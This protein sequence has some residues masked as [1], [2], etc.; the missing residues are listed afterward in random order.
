MKL[1]NKAKSTSVAGTEYR[2]SIAAKEWTPGV[3]PVES[4][5]ACVIRRRVTYKEDFQNVNG[6]EAR[7]RAVLCALEIADRGTTVY[8]E[9]DSF[10]AQ[11]LRGKRPVKEPKLAALRTE[12]CDLIL[13]RKLEV[14]YI[15][16]D[17]QD[18]PAQQL[19]D[20]DDEAT[21]GE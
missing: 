4:M 3:G 19:V 11:E 14:N 1:K 2:I 6:R 12:I 8:I 20:A 21:E 13:E 15:P 18:N 7:Y 17:R 9:T 16:V 10:H 5:F